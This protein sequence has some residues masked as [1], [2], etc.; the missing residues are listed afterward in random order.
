VTTLEDFVSE[1]LSQIVKGVVAAQAAVRD[2]GAQVAPFMS[3]NRGSTTVA[4]PDTGMGRAEGTMSM[5]VRPVEF[6]VALTTVAGTETKG[7]IAVFSGIIS[8]GSA[9][10]SEQSTQAVSRVKFVV[11]LLL[12]PQTPSAVRGR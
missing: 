9:G 11:P 7:G 10:K 2:S 4:K 6:D 8:A 1:T 3:E 5:P 12:P